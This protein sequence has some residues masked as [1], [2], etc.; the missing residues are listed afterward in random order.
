MLD[1]KEP[2]GSIHI[3]QSSEPEMIRIPA[4][5]FLMGSEPEKDENTHAGERPQHTLYLAAYHLAK[6]P[7]TN[8]EYA[9]FVAATGSSQPAH[10]RDG[11]PPTAK[12]NHPVV[13]VSWYDAVAY[14]QWLSHVTGK[15]Y[16]LPSEAE[17]EKAARGS[18]G[19]VY[20]WGE[21]WD[22]ARCNSKE[23]ELGDTSPAGAYPQGA[24]P[25]GLLDMAGNVYEWTLS[26]WGKDMKQPAFR[27][28]YDPSDGR[29]HLG[30]SNGILRVLRGGAFYYNAICAR[31]AHRVKSYP[32]YSVRT[33]GFRVCLH[34]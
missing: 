5:E 7:V 6:T 15:S 8:A 23:S 18:D 17:W 34:D 30:A 27:Y 22:K 13:H 9:V 25:Y 31:A 20:P 1:K 10:W 21:Q 33:R 2:P 12:E 32:D 19:R 16:S 26:L 3:T 29:E 24:S 11:N 4:G 28:P 14:C